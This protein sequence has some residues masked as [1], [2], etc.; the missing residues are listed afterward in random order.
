MQPSFREEVPILIHGLDVFLPSESEAHNFFRPDSPD[1]WQMAEAFGEMGCR[2]IVI[3]AGA[4]GQY[5]WDHEAKKRWHIPPYPVSVRDVTG[6]G[7]AYCGGFLVG[8]DKYEDIVE[9]ALRG[10][11]SASLTIEGYGPLY[12]REAHPG[13]AEAR[14]EAHRSSVRLV[15]P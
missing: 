1:V 13:L 14:L 4:S 8:Y 2:Y 7:D 10:S 6:A 3:K 15:Q 11:I 5:L 9:A 12:P